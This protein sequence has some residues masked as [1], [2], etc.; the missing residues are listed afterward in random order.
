MIYLAG[1]DLYYLNL[2][3]KNKIC[4][5]NTNLLSYRKGCRVICVPPTGSDGL[6]SPTR[7]VH[8]LLNEVSNQATTSK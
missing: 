8:H 2:V 7:K 4:N 6:V 3:P 5:A 1:L